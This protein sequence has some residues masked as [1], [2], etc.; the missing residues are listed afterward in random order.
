MALNEAETSIRRM[1][2]YELPNRKLLL[3][4]LQLIKSRCQCV[5]ISVRLPVC[6]SFYLAGCLSAYLPLCLSIF[7]LLLSGSVFLSLHIFV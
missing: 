2:V 7:F 4:T 6:L 5:A 1:D 3:C